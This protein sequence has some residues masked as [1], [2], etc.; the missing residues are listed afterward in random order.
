MKVAVFG[1][2]RTGSTMLCIALSL[3]YR[4]KFD[5][6][7]ITPPMPLEN[8]LALIQ[9]L[10]ATTDSFVAKFFVINFDD[11][12]ITALRWD[13][14]DLIVTTT[15]SSLVDAYISGWV[16]SR[17]NN[18]IKT[19]SSEWTDEAFTIDLSEMGTRTI[20]G[21]Q[22]FPA[23]LN[24]IKRLAPNTKIVETCYE[25]L[26]D[27]TKLFNILY[28]LLPRTLRVNRVIT[29]I[30]TGDTIPTGINYREKCLNYAEV[31]AKFKEMKLI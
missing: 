2:P 9:Q 29:S 24:D 14:F 31:E 7:V 19:R 25:D 20:L 11:V 23:L 22:R 18:W 15:R 12:P 10:N 3:L 6:E 5:Q 8:K 16:A 30:T 28:D 21:F 26:V 17:R 27:D 1:N 4:I 13:Q